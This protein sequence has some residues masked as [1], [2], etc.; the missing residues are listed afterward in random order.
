METTRRL[1]LTRWYRKARGRMI[2]LLAGERPCAKTQHK[3][4][5]FLSGHLSIW[6]QSF[7]VFHQEMIRQANT[8]YTLSMIKVAE[9]RRQWFPR[10][11]NWSALKTPNNSNKTRKAFLFPQCKKTYTTQKALFEGISVKT[12]FE[13]NGD[14]CVDLKCQ[15]SNQTHRKFSNHNHAG[16]EITFPL[17]NWDEQIS[18]VQNPSV[19]GHLLFPWMCFDGLHLPSEKQPERQQQKQELRSTLVCEFKTRRKSRKNY[20]E[21]LDF[22]E[23]W[24]EK[25]SWK[26]EPSHSEHLLCFRLFHRR[27][28]QLM[29]VMPFDQLNSEKKKQGVLQTAFKFTCVRNPFERWPWSFLSKSVLRCILA[30]L[31]SNE[32][33]CVRKRHLLFALCWM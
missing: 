27:G 19:Q 30:H 29:K 12:R 14:D 9:G 3:T 6:R 2:L 11:S 28:G 21:L 16:S 32:R 31:S 20:P 24:M 10:N 8:I 17:H 25:R 1:K 26:P 23:G 5:N 33:Q 4:Q 18:G 22:T 15:M 7:A 13:L